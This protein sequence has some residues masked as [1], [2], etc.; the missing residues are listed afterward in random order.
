MAFKLEYGTKAF[1]P[2]LA[3]PYLWIYKADILKKDMH[4][5]E[6]NV[7]GTG[8]F[9]FKGYVAGSHVEGVRFDDYFIKGRPYLDSFRAIF[10]GKQAPQV[11]A[12]RGGRALVNFRAFPPKTRDDLQK[13]LGA[14]LTVQESTW[15]CVLIVTPNHKV[16]PFDDPR[17]RR[18]L[19]LALDRW[20]AS[21]TILSLIH[22]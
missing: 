7:M 17:V 10:I 1:I 16:K 4:W 18:A 5:Y 2:A 11:A 3:N 9:K 13:A 20:E 6:K 8:A 15:N 22:I 21:R 14:K 19:S 12:I